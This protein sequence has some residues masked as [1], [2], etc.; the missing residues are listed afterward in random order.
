MQFY[1]LDI[2]DTDSIAAFASAL[3]QNFSRVNVLIHNAGIQRLE[4]LTAGAVFN[5]EETIATNLLGP[6]RLTAALLPMLMERR[7]AAILTVTSE[8]AFVPQAMT[9]TY[10]ATKAALHSYTQSL[11]F[12]LRDT[13]VEVIEIIPPWVQ[14]SLQ[15]DDGNNPAAMPLHDFI[16]ETMLLLQTMPAAEEIIVE[17]AKAARFAESRGDFDVAF[18]ALNGTATNSDAD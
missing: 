3:K 10:C 11:R 14:T 8:L 18:S 12:Q 16:A 5:A 6:I 13:S 1:P 4:D 9:P 2:G 15:G 7:Y 17:R